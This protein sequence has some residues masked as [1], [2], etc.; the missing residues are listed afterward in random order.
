M[1]VTTRPL[2]AR[3]VLFPGSDPETALAARLRR[4][5]IARGA[6]GRVRRLTAAALAAVDDEIA[7]VI[8]AVLGVEIG[9]ALVTGWRRRTDLVSAG[10][11]TVA[12]PGTEEIVVLQSHAVRWRYR[13]AVD[14]LVDGRR[15]T[16]IE[17]ALEVVYDVRGAV[18]IV[19][20]GEL[21]A[22]RSGD[23]ALSATLWVSEQEV[24]REERTVEAALLVT[25]DPPVRL[26]P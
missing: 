5:E 6:V 3:E 2:T 10:Q 1:T 18:A 4:Q 17:L 21:V 16:T 20:G 12:A 25:V 22:V 9:G 13:P 11:R 24:A 14:V 26:A 19:R 7:A 23:V 8:D 15:V